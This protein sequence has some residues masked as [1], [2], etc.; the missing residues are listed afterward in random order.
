MK[1]RALALLLALV[2]MVGFVQPASAAQ[3]D[4]VGGGDA[5][6]QAYPFSVALLRASGRLFCSGSLVAPTWVL[7]AA[8]CVDG[9]NPEVLSAR[10]GSNDATAGGE[11]AQPVEFVIHPDYNAVAGGDVAL[12]RLENPVKSA[13]ITLGAVTVPG[14]PTRLLGWGQTCPTLSCAPTPSKLQQLDAS[15]VEP[16]DCTAAFDLDHELCTENPGGDKGTCYGDSGGSQVG[17]VDGVW[18]LLGVISRP[19]NGDPVCATAPSI[20]SSA[21]AYAEWIKGKIAPPAVAP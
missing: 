15:I 12:I 7:T 13:P 6:D 3:P 14:T 1:K 21:V 16:T 20:S 18:V 8:H 17:N 5:P 9:K 19:G 4:I 11:I 10:V 2:A